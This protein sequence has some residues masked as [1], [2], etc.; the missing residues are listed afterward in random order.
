MTPADI[1]L[2]TIAAIAI[3]LVVYF[4]IQDKKHSTQKEG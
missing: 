1:M 3:S 2:L 4:K